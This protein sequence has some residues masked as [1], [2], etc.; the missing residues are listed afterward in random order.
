MLILRN[1]RVYLSFSDFKCFKLM[2]T[3]LILVACSF[4]QI[5]DDLLLG[6]I[7]ID[8]FL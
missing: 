5:L 8:V 1:F 2:L 6:K 3:F 4:Y 7:F